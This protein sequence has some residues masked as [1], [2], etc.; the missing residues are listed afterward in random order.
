MHARFALDRQKIR[1]R[2]SKAQQHN[3]HTSKTIFH[4]THQALSYPKRVALGIHYHP[5]L[6]S[7][8]ALHYPPVP[9]TQHQEAAED[10]SLSQHP[11]HLITHYTLHPDNT[12]LNLASPTLRLFLQAVIP[13]KLT[14]LNSQHGLALGTNPPIKST[15]ALH[16]PLMT[17]TPLSHL[18]TFPLQTRSQRTSLTRITYTMTRIITLALTRR[19]CPI[20]CLL[21]L[22]LSDMNLRGGCY[23]GVILMDRRL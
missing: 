2:L 18:P 23:R 9:P 21:P 17:S 15:T 14:S 10:H 5:H 22:L 6:S 13:P 7:L 8:E 11:I 20:Q 3:L 19:R 12:T 1:T 4:H 16:H